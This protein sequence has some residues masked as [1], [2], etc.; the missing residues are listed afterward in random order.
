METYWD[1]FINKYGKDLLNLPIVQT[2]EAFYHYVKGD[3]DASD[4]IVWP[5]KKY[6]DDE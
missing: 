6:G 4:R 1:A 5:S 3:K 2:L